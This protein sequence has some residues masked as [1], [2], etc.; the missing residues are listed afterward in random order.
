MCQLFET[1]R[2]TGGEPQ[3]LPLH[4]ERMN[5]SRRMLFDKYDQ[6]VLS[7]LIKVPEDSK[8]GIYRCRIIYSD[9][10][11]S[12]EF[13]PYTAANVKT[14]KLVDSGTLSYDFK[15][16][17][18]SHL[19]SLVDKKAADDILIL[20]NG[21]ITDAS[22]ANIVFTEGRRWVTPDTPLLC[23]TMRELLLRKKMITEERLTVEGIHRFTH[24]RLIN[25]MLGFDAPILPVSN[26][27]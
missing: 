19:T 23:G 1:I 24:F 18:R 7:D 17:D 6:I 14:L 22:F 15:Y 26:I 8:S 13:L 20:R 25:A 10:V 11:S 3:N 12:V 21:C 9:S 16:L 27:F 5:R 4:Q 2:I